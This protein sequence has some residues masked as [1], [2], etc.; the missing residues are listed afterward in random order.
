MALYK[1][2]VI[3]WQEP[4]RHLKPVVVVSLTRPRNDTGPAAA[5]GLCR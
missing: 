5:L 4:W 2:E 3:R 1:T